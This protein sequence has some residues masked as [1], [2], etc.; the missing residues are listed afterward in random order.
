MDAAG[1]GSAVGNDA[2]GLSPM[3]A[4]LVARDADYTAA[5]GDSAE[6]RRECVWSFTLARFRLVLFV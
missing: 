3:A 4:F 5:A 2:R 1:P 6:V